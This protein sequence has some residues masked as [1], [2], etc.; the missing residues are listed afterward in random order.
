MHLD[1]ML[2]AKRSEAKQSKANGSDSDHH[3]RF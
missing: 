2:Q 3:E 1:L